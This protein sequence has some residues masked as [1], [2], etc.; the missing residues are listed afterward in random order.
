[1]SASD[2]GTPEAPGLIVRP[3][4]SELTPQ[5][6]RTLRQAFAA[7]LADGEYARIAGIY[8]PYSQHHTA[9]F[10]P[11]HRAYLGL[12][13]GALRRAAGDAAIP[14]WD[15]WNEPGLPAAF[16]P[17]VADGQANPLYAAGIPPE[18]VRE[19]Q[20]R[21]TGPDDPD[22][23]RTTRA[24]G[25]GRVPLPTPGSLQSAL[26]AASFTDFATR[27]EA[28]HDQLHVW[29]GG[30]SADVTRG[31]YDPISWPLAAS[32]DQAWSAWQVRHP[33]AMPDNLLS[34]R[35][36]PESLGVTVGG[37]LD[38]TRLGYRY[39]RVTD[40]GRVGRQVVLP[41]Y[42][43]DNVPEKP[44]DL[45]DLD[46]DLNSL[47][48]VI[49]D[50]NT[51][52]PLA[53]GLFGDWGSGKSTFMAL[54]RQKVA[55][56]TKPNQPEIR[57]WCINVRQIVF[58]A[59][60][61][62]EDNLWASLV[63]H[64]FEQLSVPALYDR[65]G[66]SGLLGQ[67]AAERADATK[68]LKDAQEREEQAS[69]ALGAIS[70]ADDAL[71]AVQA[72]GEA[73][74][75]DDQI[76]KTVGPEAAKALDEAGSIAGVLRGLWPRVRAFGLFLRHG[77]R[78]RYLALALLVAAAGLIAASV[79]IARTVGWPAVLSALAAVA[80][81]GGSLQ[82]LIKA[83]QAIR[84]SR[85]KAEEHKRS[86]EAARDRAIG[87][88]AT[89]ETRLADV[90]SGKFLDTYFA[91]RAASSDYQSRLG[92]L[93][94][95]S[96]DFQDLREW[97]LQGSIDGRADRVERIILYI[98]DLD[99][100]NA[101]RV[102]QVLEAIHLM[103]ALDLFVVVVAVD[104]RWLLS[105]L[106]EQ[107]S[108]EFGAVAPEYQMWRTTPQQYLE[109]I[110]QIPF[111]L[112][113][114]SASGFGRIIGNMLPSSAANPAGLAPVAAGADAPVSA[115][116]AAAD[117][118]QD[119]LL[120]ATAPV[121][122]SYDLPIGLLVDPREVDFM[123]RLNVLIPTPRAAK[124]FV[125]TYRLIRAPLAGAELSA[126]VGT[127]DYPGPYKGVMLLLAIMIGYPAAAEQIF[128]ALAAADGR[129]WAEVL[130]KAE[131]AGDDDAA[132][133]ASVLPDL[134]RL[135]PLPEPG[136]MRPWLSAVSRYSFR[137]IVGMADIDA[138]AVDGP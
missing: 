114:M 65:P 7:V 87:D 61:Y 76:R 21:G 78:K 30:T 96:H 38:T 58:N 79:V 105:S 11:W 100:C 75:D 39:A 127:E 45:L 123:C 132:S 10:L 2:P 97:L 99:R 133:L 14:A 85:Q 44:N 83:D 93:S 89:A 101:A 24:P 81:V 15:W 88:R 54:L 91:R 136:L 16:A 48:W 62:A 33:G 107:Y 12:L 119:V 63:T 9:L 111:N 103:L 108:R 74:G 116:E 66:G 117:G 56:L 37:V 34:V 104:P 98:D 51:A 102:V 6:V 64:I 94:T 35:L 47:T 52:P 31:A 115:G 25:L 80:A 41:G 46:A 95:V 113:P 120:A 125:N 110:F 135:E 84:D 131:P 49:A 55:E 73:L 69:D 118:Q 67:I 20:A 13:E 138:P 43:S 109:K 72:A 106:A 122:A 22:A 50:R 57:P 124:R 68:S 59:W 70:R 40:T 121:G 134:R 29:V 82:P 130:V 3:N 71:A 26:S 60:Q 53:I 27:I 112:R 92:L 42:F 126:F 86:L 4:T 128:P 8:A 19:V 5:Q 32:I 36:E 18:V 129:S 90:A 137:R 1:M 23:A 28:I 17:D 77:G